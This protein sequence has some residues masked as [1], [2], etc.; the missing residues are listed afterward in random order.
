MPT[1]ITINPDFAGEVYIPSV[2]KALRPGQFIIVEDSIAKSDDI[3]KLLSKKIIIVSSPDEEP[4]SVDEMALNKNEKFRVKNL[5]NRNLSVQGLKQMLT[6]NGAV[7]IDYNTLV[8]GFIGMLLKSNLAEITDMKGNRVVLDG[9]Y[10]FKKAK[11]EE[12][13]SEDKKIL[14]ETAISSKNNKETEKD[15]FKNKISIKSQEEVKYASNANKAPY[16]N[17][18]TKDAFGD[19]VIDP[20]LDKKH[21]SY[22][23]DAETQSARVGKPVFSEIEEKI[24]S[25]GEAYIVP[26]KKISIKSKNDIE[27]ALSVE[28]ASD[29]RHEEEAIEEKM[30]KI[31][32][33]A[34]KK[35]K[36][37]KTKRKI[38][39]KNSID[40]VVAELKNNKKKTKKIGIKAIGTKKEEVSAKDI[41]DNEVILHNK[42]SFFVD[43]EQEAERI[44]KHPLFKRMNNIE[45]E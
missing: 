34:S 10:G 13:P 8:S 27:N 22:V 20:L 18:I 36:G 16:E 42:D 2:K 14:K 39:Q 6:P 21:T 37:P 26:N 9:V 33:K 35:K 30:E 12:Q 45:I 1:K 4:Q 7:Y 15:T 38:E 43:Q 40:K 29:E 19:F 17:L 5:T 25:N 31:A 28:K 32:K 41:N 24:P 3:A 44:T 23:W 11:Q